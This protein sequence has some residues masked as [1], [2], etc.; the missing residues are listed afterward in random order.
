M[1]EQR[2]SRSES[3]DD[4]LAA[5]SDAAPLKLEH[6]LPYQLMVVASLVVGSLHSR[7]WWEK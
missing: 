1:A 6:F 3:A 4:D 5:A 2:A 7:V